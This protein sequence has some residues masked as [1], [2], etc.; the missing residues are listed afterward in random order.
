MQIWYTTIRCQGIFSSTEMNIV[1]N[2]GRWC[3]CGTR[4]WRNW[5]QWTLPEEGEGCKVWRKQWW[6]HIDMHTT[7]DAG[8]DH[9]AAYDQL[10]MD[11]APS[12]TLCGCR[13]IIDNVYGCRPQ[14]CRATGV[15][16]ACDKT[17]NNVSYIQPS[18]AGII[19]LST[20]N[21]DR[22]PIFPH[23]GQN[24]VC[25]ICSLQNVCA[26]RTFHTCSIQNICTQRT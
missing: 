22:R 23:I 21:C 20:V 19:I 11:R 3:W 5:L 16:H 15:L 25:Y 14:R 4:I 1:Q 17:R 18:D 2:H 26:V 10:L 6:V 13:G 24:T 8:V 12:G 9:A 7:R